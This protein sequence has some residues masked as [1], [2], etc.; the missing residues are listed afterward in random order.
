MGF[1][2][3]LFNSTRNP[4]PQYKPAMTVKT[5]ASD[6]ASGGIFATILTYAW[7]SIR[8]KNPAWPQDPEIDAAILGAGVGLLTG[9]FGGIKN[10]AKNR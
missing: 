7:T 6:L 2:R 1:L 4:N 3:D 5:G 10:W 8:A 9:L